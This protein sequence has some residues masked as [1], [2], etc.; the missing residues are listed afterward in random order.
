MPL[1]DLKCP[2]GHI[3]EVYLKSLQ[4]KNEDCRNCGKETTRIYS[5]SS[6]S[7]YQE[8]PFVTTHITGKPLE[9]RDRA[10]FERV[11][12]AHNLTHRPDIAWT[13]K[14]YV[15]YNRKTRKQEYREASGR[16]LPG[17]WV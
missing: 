16:G 10:H 2:D 4:T 13:E 8:F 14:E 12:K 11:L 7:G 5:I 15:G 1:F 6:Q 9:I 17:C 3:N